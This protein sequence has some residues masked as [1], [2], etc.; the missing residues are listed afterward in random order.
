MRKVLLT[1][2]ALLAVTGTASGTTTYVAHLSSA[3]TGTESPATGTGI[4]VLSDDET[5]V[6]YNVSYSALLGAN[7]GMHVH[8]KVGGIIFDLGTGINPSIGTWD[9]I[10]PEDVVRLKT[11]GLFI[12]VHSDLYPAGEIQGPLLEDAAPVRNST[13]GE[14]KALYRQ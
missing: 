9:T 7:T 10:L 4:L 5:S 3:K 8:R 1:A 14:I 12:N 2:I 11:G 6:D 13:W